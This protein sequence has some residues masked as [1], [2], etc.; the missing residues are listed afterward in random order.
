MLTVTWGRAVWTVYVISIHRSAELTSGLEV[1]EQAVGKF[2]SSLFCCRKING[3]S[4]K[5]LIWALTAWDNT[6][7][8]E[9]T[10]K[11]T[12]GF[13]LFSYQVVYMF[14]SSIVCSKRQW[15]HPNNSCGKLKKSVGFREIRY[16]GTMRLSGR[17]GV[18]EAVTDSLHCLT[19]QTKQGAKAW[20]VL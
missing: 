18:Q 17:T 15:V 13:L 2:P 8:A 1:G 14:F 20:S 11:Q 6:R 10:G 5:S 3:I 9:R 19:A 12:D 7:E 16:D 4:A